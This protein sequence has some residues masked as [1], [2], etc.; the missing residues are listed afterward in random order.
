VIF[1]NSE[2]LYKISPRLGISHVIADGATFTFNY[3]LYYQTPIYEF[4]YR[5]ISKLED[6]SEAFEDAG[7]ENQSI[8]NATMV[9]GRTQSYEMAFNVQFSRRWAFSAGLWVKDMDQLTTAS[10]YNSGVYEYKVAKNGDFGTAIGFDFTVENRGRLFNTTI[11]Y[12]YSTAKASSAYDAEA[13]GAIQVD[14]PQLETLMPYDR[15]HDLTLILYSTKLPWGL[16]GGIT[17]FFQSGEPYTP[18]IFN[19]NK[20]EEDLKNEYSKRA[21]SMFNMDM[22][23][24]K[25]WEMRK[26]KLMLGVNI[27][28]VFNKP[29]PHRVYQLTGTPDRPGEYYEDD[30]GTALS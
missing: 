19:G 14:A 21:P 23:V 20:P 15:S 26:H 9:A 27:F 29:Y 2:W 3:G 16:N 8:G 12:T 5:N 4:I 25:G 13:F 17:G 10:V 18:M 6:P 11:Q 24:S 28:N 22:S 1:K 7:E 30:I